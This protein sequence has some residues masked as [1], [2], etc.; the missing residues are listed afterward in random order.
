MDLFT[1]APVIPSL[2][3]ASLRLPENDDIQFEPRFNGKEPLIEGVGARTRHHH[4]ATLADSVLDI[5]VMA[6][7]TDV[8]EEA[9]LNSSVFPPYDR[10]DMYRHSPSMTIVYCVAYF[11]VFAMGLVGNCLVVAVVFRAPRM[12]TVTNLFIVNLAI[13]DILVVVVCIPATLISN[14]FVRKS[15]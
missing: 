8:L 1:Q 11:I 2:Q 5:Y 6:N 13:A 14:I 15:F 9:L 12:R 10:N 4:R 3:S 7:L